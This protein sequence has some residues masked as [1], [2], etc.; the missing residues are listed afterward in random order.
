MT[1]RALPPEIR[2][3]SGS[4]RRPQAARSGG[5]SNKSVSSSKSLAHSGARRFSSRLIRRFFLS[6]GVRIEH[7]AGPLPR[8]PLLV[9]LSADGTPRRRRAAPAGQMP[10][11]QWNG[12]LHGLV[13]EAV[14]DLSQA[15]SESCAQLL[16][17]ET[18]T[19]PTTVV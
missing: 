12:P 3:G 17:P 14:G 15:R 9:E 8:V 4:P 19:I 6:L 16:A 1:R 11:E 2:T 13:T 10:L 18:G 5:K 7:I